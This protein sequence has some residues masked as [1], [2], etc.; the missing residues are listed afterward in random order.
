M[1]QSGAMIQEVMLFNDHQ[2]IMINKKF[3]LFIL[4]I[5]KFPF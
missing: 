2:L 3:N 1:K 4:K 5:K